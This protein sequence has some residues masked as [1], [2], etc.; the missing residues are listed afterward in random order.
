[1]FKYINRDGSLAK[2]RHLPNNTLITPKSAKSSTHS[3]NSLNSLTNMV[4]FSIIPSSLRKSKK[5]RERTK[6][7]WGEEKIENG[8]KKDIINSY[9]SNC[10]IMSTSKVIIPDGM[11]YSCTKFSSE[12]NV[13]NVSNALIST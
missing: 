5:Q 12:L 13:A 7:K 10:F 9:Q 2:I 8:K 1:M 11:T 4:D 6:D 3:S